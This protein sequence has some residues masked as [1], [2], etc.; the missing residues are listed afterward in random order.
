[1]TVRLPPSPS[2]EPLVFTSIADAS[3]V[4][5]QLLA[6]SNQVAPAADLLPPPATAGSLFAAFPVWGGGGGFEVWGFL[7]NTVLVTTTSDFHTWG[8]SLAV[9]TAVPSLGIPKSCDRDDAAGVYLCLTFVS[10]AVGAVAFRCAAP[11]ARNGCEPVGGTWKS[12][13]FYDHDDINLIFDASRARWVDVQVALVPAHVLN[14]TKPFCDNVQGDSMRVVTTRIAPAAAGGGGWGAN[15]ACLGAQVSQYCPG[16]FNASAGAIFRP[17][18]SDP[19][20]LQFYRLRPFVLGG[21]SARLVGHALIYAPSP[22]DLPASARCLGGVGAPG[23]C[24]HGPHI[25][26]EFWIGPTSGDPAD[27][28][29]WARPFAGAPRLMMP[30][31]VYLMPQPQVLPGG[32]GG[33]RHVFLD[34][35]TGTPGAAVWTLP[36]HRLAG[37]RAAANAAFTTAPFALPAAGLALNADAAW[38][39]PAGQPGDEERGGY[40]MAE[41]LDAV[42]GAPF[43]GLPR[44]A[45]ALINATGVALPLAWPGAP[46][47]MPPPG[48]SV[49]LRFYLRA[50]TVYAVYARGSGS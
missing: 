6:I 38:P 3:S 31:G 12:T 41:L 48:T 50:A 18:A 19:P 1:M 7:N 10:D 45:S 23:V 37:L 43:P 27:L 9:A 46:G 35:A 26:D 4:E 13:A 28:A 36:L 5:G 47:P 21:G 32:A 29:G 33:A 22:L 40:V 2:L 16:P 15:S 25:G 30:P 20:E 8:A 39:V 44:N 24:C 14:R 42:T 17:S 34:T 11:L 49:R